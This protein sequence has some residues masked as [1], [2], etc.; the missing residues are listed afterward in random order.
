MSKSHSSESPLKYP[1]NMESPL[2]S[3][4]DEADDGM[5]ISDDEIGIDFYFQSQLESTSMTSTQN[6]AKVF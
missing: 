6:N 1:P 4:E 2:S 3:N 5:R